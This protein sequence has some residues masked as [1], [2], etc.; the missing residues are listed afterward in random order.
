VQN[1]IGDA[2]ARSNHLRLATSNLE[3]LEINLRTFKSD[4]EE[5]DLEKAITDLVGRQ[6]A[7]QAAM[8]AT[9]RVMGM[10]MMDY[11]R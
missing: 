10:T 11:L 5:V 9:S 1:L 2:G 6:T 8:M 7:Y 4:L 3:A